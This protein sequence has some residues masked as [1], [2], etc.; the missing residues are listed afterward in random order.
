MDLFS[1][2]VFRQAAGAFLLILLTLT[3]IV[4][5]ATALAQL[6]LLTSQG[7]SMILFFKMTSLAV[8]GLLA[9][10]A[11]M[12]LLIAVI[13]TLDRLNGDSELIVVSASGATVWHIAKPYV[14]LASLVCVFVLLLN[15]L[16]APASLRTLRSYI[17]QVRTDL[18]SQV[19]QPGRFSSPEQ[20]L[21]FH[22]RERNPNGDLMGLVIHD[23][24]EPAQVMTYLA[25]RA[26]L[27]KTDKG[28]FLVMHTGHVH[29][30]LA[31]Q[32][33]KSV[34]VIGYDRYIFDISKFGA[35]SSSGYLKPRERY[36]GELL[37]PIDEKDAFFVHFPGR[38]RAELHD[39]FARALYPLTHVFVILFFLAFARTSRQSRWGT[40]LTALGCAVAIRMA[41]LAATNLAALEA[42][43]VALV[44]GVPSV[45]IVLAILAI[46]ARLT[47][48]GM[49]LLASLGQIRRRAE[50]ALR[51]LLPA[52]GFR[53]SNKVGT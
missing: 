13:H 28:T 49:S 27:E 42:W 40:V 43:G 45:A 17:V 37:A 16:V 44:Y 23:R 20:G 53:L 29:R 12:A 39:R 38:I 47:P 10:I 15:L 33:E 24:R 4:W 34:Q 48:R 25:E 50:D 46:Q 18:I 5:I 36:I 22:I 11:P 21:T 52:Q 26:R 9:L 3:A 19:L 6:K 1:R 31:D 41:G 8:P 7:Q 14:A 30:R 2:Y 32:K 35:K 51:A